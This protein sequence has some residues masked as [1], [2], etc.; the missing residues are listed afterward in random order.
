MNLLLGYYDP[1]SGEVL[2]DELN[3]QDLHIR[4]LRS[5]INYV[6]QEPTLFSGS[7]SDNIARGRSGG[8]HCNLLTLQEVMVEEQKGRR[9]L[10]SFSQRI[11]IARAL[12]EQPA[13]L[14]LDEA[15]SALD[16]ASER[17]VQQSIDA[18]QASKAQTT[19]VIVHTLSTIRNA[20]KIVV[21]DCGSVVEQGTHDEL[22]VKNGLYASLWEKQSGRI[23]N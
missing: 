12:I 1:L 6:G 2:L 8:E 5:Q 20:D 4:W 22:L 16:I 18:L 19:I 11:A 14:L 7:V 15:T 17:Y 3:I 23:K 13:I 9:C 21:I 10:A